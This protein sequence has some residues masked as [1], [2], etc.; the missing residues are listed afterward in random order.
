MPGCRCGS[1][2]RPP[3]RAAGGR[4]PC[5]RGRR[6]FAAAFAFAIVLL[7]SFAALAGEGG[8]GLGTSFSH[9]MAQ[10]RFFMES[11]LWPQALVEFQAA[12]EMAQGR[13]DPEVHTLIA[14]AS[15]RTGD[16]AAAVEAVRTAQSLSGSPPPPDLA[17]LHEFLTT[18]FGKVMVIGAEASDAWVPEPSAPILDP[19]LKRIFEGAVRRLAGPSR[20]GSTSIY[21]PVGTYRVGPHL[22]QVGS[23]GIARMDLRPTV[24]LAEGGVY[25]ERKERGPSRPGARRGGVD[26]G[27]RGAADSW[28]AIE[29]GGQVFAQQG[30]AAGGGRLI[31][32]WEGHA[33]V[34]AGIRLAGGI[35]ILRL[36][37]IVAPVPAP[38]GFL[39]LAQVA[40]GPVIRPGRLLLLPWLGLTAGYGHPVEGAL[41]AGYQGPVSYVVWGPDV[42]LRLATGAVVA[43]AARVRAQF[44]LRA[45]LREARPVGPGSERDPRPH[46][47]VGAGVD[48][49]LL[50]GQA[51]EDAR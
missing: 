34:P 20:S 17:E 50:F 33:A 21:L 30:T 13:L 24:G 18:R 41:P 6:R 10:G 45:L 36:E 28:A 26:G 1:E 11:G 5:A 7:L 42:E 2:P 15:Y 37:R 35:E 4:A 48:F 38:G 23:E 19:E 3:R 9:R 16:V 29:V 8:E 27:R 49:G 31:A 22:V 14:R 32:G 25:G 44:G 12:A 40:G 47:D 43:G 46:L 39:P 51:E